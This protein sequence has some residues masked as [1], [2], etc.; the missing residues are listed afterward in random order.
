MK[1]IPDEFVITSLDVIIRHNLKLGEGGFAVVYEGDWKGT[2]VAVKVL[3]RG[4]PASV[5]LSSLDCCEQ[6]LTAITVGDPTRGE[7][8]ETA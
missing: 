7:R 2:R 4:V 6:C 8:L 3:E 5:S 1:A